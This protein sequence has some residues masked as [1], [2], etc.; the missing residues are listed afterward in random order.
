MGSL[1]MLIDPFSSDLPRWHPKRVFFKVAVAAGEVLARP[2]YERVA[3]A[4][5]FL[6]DL[7]PSP[8]NDARSA[9]SITHLQLRYLLA[10]VQCSEALGGVVVELG[11]FQGQTTRALAMSTRRQVVAVDCYHPAWKMAQ[12]ALMRFHENTSNLMNVVLE[13]NSSGESVREWRYGPASLLFIDAQHNFV[14]TSFDIHAWLPLLLPGGLL[15]LH[16]TDSFA[17]A[18]TRLA[19]WLASK[20]LLLWAH[21]ENLVILQ[22]PTSGFGQP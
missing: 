1:A 19:A 10:A 7:P 5:R 17:C 9:L 22:K 8:D 11:A 14:N 15:A 20:H 6:T 4:D 21:I 2:L 12:S 13:R 3:I 16:D 18:G